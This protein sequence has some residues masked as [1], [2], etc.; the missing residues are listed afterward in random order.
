METSLVQVKDLKKRYKRFQLG[1]L[2]LTV[3][4]GMV[5]G[6]VGANGS[7]KSTLFQV[8]MNI[9]KEDE[10]QIQFFGKDRSPANANWKE[11]IGFAGEL[12]EGFDY[13]TI[14]EIKSFISH[15][16]PRWDEDAFEYFVKRYQIE[17]DKKYGKCSKG[18][19]KKVEFIFTLCHDPTLLL[20]DE[21]SAGVDLVSR[22]KMKEDLI[23]FMENGDKSIVLATHTIDEINTL[24]DEIVVLHEGHIVCSYNKDDIYDNWARIW[25]SDLTDNMKQHPNVI[26]F[27]TAP[28]QVITNDVKALEKA[29]QEEKINIHQTQRLAMEEVLE[30]LI[31]RD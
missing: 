31:D 7:G 2:D 30:Y 12:L 13:L 9:T 25:T 18:T 3:E 4:T 1:P 21:P 8:L 29:L 14:S 17:L 10:G 19:K 16:Y 22:R 23:R 24:C 6:L 26:R 20:L 5:V 11:K 28:P 15:W 27:E